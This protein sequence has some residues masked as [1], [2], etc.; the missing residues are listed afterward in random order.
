MNLNKIYQKC[1]RALKNLK[2]HAHIVIKKEEHLL[3][4]DITSTTANTN[5][6]SVLELSCKSIIF[7]FNKQ[8]LTDATLPAWILKANG[9]TY[10]VNHVNADMQWSTHE[11]I[12]NPHT[13]GS[14]KFKN[15]YCSIG[16]DNTAYLRP[17]TD[18]DRAR[19]KAKDNG[20]TRILFGSNSS[21][22]VQSFMAEREIKY[23][24][25]VVIRG[26][27]GN[28]FVICDIIKEDEA[29]LALLGLAG[30]IRVL[31]PNE[32]Y[33]RAYDDKALAESIDADG[34]DEDDED[35]D[36]G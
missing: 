21:V 33:W 10:Y 23:S 8:S 32:K 4:E 7:S 14:I 31:Q 25:F 34:Y 9:N 18:I 15:C 6:N 20:Y 12:N 22:H 36:N 27:C 30:I 3:W 29:V 1:I 35:D 2:L 13:K 11:T 19:I 28:G 24:P 26:T 5:H 16:D 17:L